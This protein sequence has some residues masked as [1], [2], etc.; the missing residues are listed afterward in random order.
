MSFSSCISNNDKKIPTRDYPPYRLIIE[1]S[2][3]INPETNLVLSSYGINIGLHRGYNYKN[4][5]GN[6]SATYRLIKSKNDE[7][8]LEKSRDLLVFLIENLLQ[9][10]NSNPEIGPYLDSRPFLSDSLRIALYFEDEKRIQ[11]GQG[12]A[13]VYLSKGKIKYE[14]YKIKEYSEK[15][16]ALGEHYIIHEESYAEA[17]DIV[18]KQGNLKILN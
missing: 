18:K 4:G 5:I 14:G 1:Y 10:I 9:D 7:V 2:N 17:L 13:L 11:L 16:P 6:F 3:K 8:S 15:Y 12:V